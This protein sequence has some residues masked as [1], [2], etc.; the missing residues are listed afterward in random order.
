KTILTSLRANGE[1]FL[2]MYLE[3]VNAK[4]IPQAIIIMKPICPKKMIVSGYHTSDDSDYSSQGISDLP[5]SEPESS[6][7]KIVM[8]DESSDESET[9]DKIVEIREN[10]T[11]QMMTDQPTTNELASGYVSESEN[12]DD[13]SPTRSKNKKIS[14]KIRDLT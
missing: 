8:L 9:T 1:S 12:D 4:D 14:P 13:K 11:P 7:S 3:Q 2:K 10:P 5:L 6:S